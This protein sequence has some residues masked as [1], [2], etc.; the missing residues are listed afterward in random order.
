M[1]T[2]P[3]K[4]VTPER[5]PKLKVLHFDGPLAFRKVLRKVRDQHAD[6]TDMKWVVKAANY[7]KVKETLL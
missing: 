2:K 4:P 6:G 5:V 3:E 7:A 1:P